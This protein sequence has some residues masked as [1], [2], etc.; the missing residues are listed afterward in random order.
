MKKQG[1]IGNRG[2]SQTNIGGNFKQS[3]L[4]DIAGNIGAMEYLS[5]MKN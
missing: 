4:Q 2:I 1:N 5:T 3:K